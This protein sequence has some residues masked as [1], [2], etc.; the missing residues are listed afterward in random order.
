M[1]KSDIL[2]GNINATLKEIVL[3]LPSVLKYQPEIME[4]NCEPCSCAA[5]HSRWLYQMCTGREM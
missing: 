3:F 2:V 4:C 1:S 5:L